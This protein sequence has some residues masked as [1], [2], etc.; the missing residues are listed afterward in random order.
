MMMIGSQNYQLCVDLY[1]CKN[2]R[3]DNSLFIVKN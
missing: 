2:R 3:G 1:D